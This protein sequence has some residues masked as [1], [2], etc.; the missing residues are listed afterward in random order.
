MKAFWNRVLAALYFY[1][2]FAPV[3]ML[4]GS[5]LVGSFLPALAAAAIMMP[6][7]L[8]IVLLPEKVG[9]KK[10]KAVQQARGTGDP[11][12]DRNLRSDAM[13]V[14][15]R[16]RSFPLRMFFLIVCAIV[17]LLVV[18]FAPVMG[19]EGVFVFYRFLLGASLSVMMMMSEYC[20]ATG[21]ACNRT[22]ILTGI[23]VYLGIGFLA[24]YAMED[25]VLR[26]TMYYM[27]A[28]FLLITGFLLNERTL[29]AGA[30]SSQAYKAPRSIVIRN[31]VILA[32]FAVIVGVISQF[33]NL[34]RIASNAFRGFLR[35]IV[36]VIAWINSFIEPDTTYVAT[37][38][39][40]EIAEVGEEAA[41]V[42]AKWSAAEIAG[43]VFAFVLG[44]VLLVFLT[45]K[46][47]KWTKNFREKLK[48]WMKGFASGVGEDYEDVRESLMDFKE[49][50]ENFGETLK[51]RL[52]KL[53]RRDPKWADLDARAKVR[54]LL[55][56][57]YRKNAET[58][59]EYSQLTAREALSVMRSGFKKPEDFA[60]LYDKA[61]YSQH[62]VTEDEADTAKREA[63]L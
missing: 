22:A 33:D 24:T 23:V 3:P 11:D 44:V 13:P 60:D 58:V 19:L 45:V 51:Q 46:L 57:I 20:I 34:R 30:I 12:P 55:T 25:M 2:C 10:K 39:E 48:E 9:G 15:N 59:P 53:V 1:L 32:V 7:S 5:W 31:R 18:L 40:Q 21:D 62:D 14:K 29:S 50:R 61:R 54:F 4:L 27:G 47:L 36:R 52:A 35:A 6:V 16:S 28:A 42:A 17:I 43:I 41:K 56:L 8:L 49:A 26:T 37:Q 63:R 38:R